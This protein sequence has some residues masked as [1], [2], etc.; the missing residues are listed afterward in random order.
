MCPMP[1]DSPLIYFYYPVR[2]KDLLLRHGR[3][4]WRLLRGD[5]ETQDLVKQKNEI[6]Y[7]RDWLMSS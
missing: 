5:K 3:Q 1:S 2:I 7:L 6:A 4:A